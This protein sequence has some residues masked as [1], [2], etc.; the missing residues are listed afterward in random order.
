MF[1][2]GHVCEASAFIATRTDFQ[3]AVAADFHRV[4]FVG[5]IDKEAT[6]KSIL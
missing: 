6:T 1:S 5:R 3:C 4:V 2:S